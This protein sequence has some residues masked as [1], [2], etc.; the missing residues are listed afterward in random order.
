MI[1]KTTFSYTITTN[2]D[3]EVTIPGKANTTVFAKTH[4]IIKLSKNEEKTNFLN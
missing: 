4:N 2:P 3:Y 1:V